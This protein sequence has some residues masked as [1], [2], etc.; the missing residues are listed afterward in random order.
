MIQS[1]LDYL[2]DGSCT[3]AA[4]ADVATLHFSIFFEPNLLQI[5]Q[6]PVT[7]QVMSMAHSVSVLGTF[8]A[9]RALPAHGTPP[10][11]RVSCGLNSKERQSNIQIT[12]Q[13]VIS[14]LWWRK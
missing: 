7:G 10:D 12:V 11:N 5:G 1:Y 14:P 2:F 13:Q 8:V 9:D 6:P 3:D 4:G